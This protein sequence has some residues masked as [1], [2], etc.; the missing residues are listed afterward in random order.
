[1]SGTGDGMDLCCKCCYSLRSILSFVKFS[2]HVHVQYQTT[3][4]LQF[5]DGIV[6][7]ET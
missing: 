3:L 6:D 2:N 1:M 7:Y 4:G 5:N